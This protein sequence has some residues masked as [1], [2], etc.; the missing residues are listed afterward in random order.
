MSI[1]RT[2]RLRATA[3]SLVAALALSGGLLAASAA[4]SAESADAPTHAH[5]HTGTDVSA[6]TAL[7]RAMRTL[8]I[9]HMEWTYATVVAFAEDSP[10]LGATLDRLLRNQVDIGEA[11]APFYG[12]D[13][14]AQLTGLLTTHIELAVPVLTAAKAGDQSA[15]DPAVTAWYANAKDI[16]D[17][18]A[19]A[20]AEWPKRELRNMMA[21]HI[22][23]TVDYAG[24]VLAGD[25]A[26]AIVAY[27]AAE[28][29]MIEM[30]DMLSQGLIAQ[31]PDRF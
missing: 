21:A 17:F 2:A 7:H 23:T 8:W 5:A 4:G 20:N 24:K 26:S 3:A 11:V 19:S 10:A 28:A 1:P 14:A 16:A 13:A 22:T 18:L 25:H 30:A 27:D 15:L 6:E 31:F 29:H 12:E 9:Q